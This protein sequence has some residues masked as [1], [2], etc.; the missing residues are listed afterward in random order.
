MEQWTLTAPLSVPNYQVQALVLDWPGAKIKVI[1]RDPNGETIVCVYI[2]AE[3]TTLMTSLN[4]ANL[5]AQSLHKR[6]LNQLAA[7]GKIGAGAVSGAPD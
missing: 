5:A 7:D 4:K 3:A 6:I 1:L 2:G